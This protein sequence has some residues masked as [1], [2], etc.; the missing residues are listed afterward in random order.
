MVCKCKAIHQART[1]YNILLARHY[2]AIAYFDNP[3]ISKEQ[4]EKFIPQYKEIVEALGDLL[5]TIGEYSEVEV[6]EGFREEV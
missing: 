3:D 1:Q 6:L 2:K 5:D 4:K